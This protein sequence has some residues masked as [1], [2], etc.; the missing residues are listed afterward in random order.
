MTPVRL[1]LLIGQCR[2]NTSMWLVLHTHGCSGGEVVGV[3]VEEEIVGVCTLDDRKHG[4]FLLP[5]T[6]KMKSIVIKRGN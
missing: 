3:D 1:L 5:E 2:I 4:G 6:C